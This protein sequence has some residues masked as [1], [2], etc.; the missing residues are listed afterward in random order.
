MTGPLDA[1][2]LFDAVGRDYEEAFGHQ[3]IA[4]VA[5]R[6]LLD[7]LP[8]SARVLDI[9]SGTGRPV[10]AALTGAGHRVLGVDVSDRM[11]AIAREQVPDADFVRADI[12]EWDSAAGSW[13]AVCAFFSFLQMTRDE[14]LRLLDRGARWLK[15]GG[16]LAVATVPMDVEGVDTDFLGHPIRVTSFAA[17]DLLRHVEQ[18]GFEVVETREA[19]FAP[20][21]DRPAEQQFLVLATP[22]PRTPPTP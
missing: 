6:L 19:V 4:D 14:V 5:V 20:H 22:T 3:P 8:E 17:P 18:A 15:P 1:A 7:R 16:L 13:D 21:A 2:E 10:A 11:V 9:G 12:R